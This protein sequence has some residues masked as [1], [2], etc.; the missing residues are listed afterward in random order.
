MPI[1]ASPEY[2]KANSEYLSAVGTEQKIRALKKMISLAPKHKGSENLLKQLKTRLKKLKYSKEKE[3][4]NSKGGKEGI[5]KLEMQALIIGKTNTGKS[6]ILKTL[7]NT[8]PE[9][10]NYSFTTKQPLVGM[11]DYSGVQ[12]QLIE[13]P[14]IE[15][16]YFDKGLINTADTI[17]II[18]N[19]LEEIPPA[20]ETL[21][22]SKSLGKRIIVF[23]KI[24]PLS[25][26][27]KRKISENLK[28][29]KLNFVLTSTIS[30]QGIQE[31][32]DKIF[33]SFDKIRIYTK[34]P[35]KEK[36]DAKKEKPIILE[37]NSTIYDV[38][39]KILKGFSKQ[40]K[41]TRIWGP[42]S[43]FPAQKV[44]MKHEV[45]DLDIVEF[46]TR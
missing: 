36:E 39:E 9:I 22:K 31:L 19:N 40:V 18:I 12:V 11:I 41:E 8:K 15:S 28:S 1:N 20:I 4:K 17:L 21:N 3:S 6:S 29:K 2:D 34:D 13:N 14:A 7:T 43:K 10:A 35:N 46:K 42:S 25:E 38:S 32:R 45:K 37:P 26:N 5:K 33:Q 24:D 27:Q 30:K 23:N 16:E 44:G